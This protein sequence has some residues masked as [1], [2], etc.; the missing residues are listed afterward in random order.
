MGIEPIPEDVYLASDPKAVERAAKRSKTQTNSEDADLLWLMR[1]PQ[2]RRFM[3]RRLGLCGLYRLSFNPKAP[4]SHCAAFAEGERNTALNLLADIA[5]AA[6]A[7][8]LQMIKEST[9]AA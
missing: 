5:R 3:W 7:E 9:D 6:P 1:Q 8:Y 4:D 2:G